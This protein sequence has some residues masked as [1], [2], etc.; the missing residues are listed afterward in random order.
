MVIMV[1]M[2]LVGYLVIKSNE[3]SSMI[4]DLHTLPL[5]LFRSMKQSDW[6]ISIG[7]MPLNL[8]GSGIYMKLFP[9]QQCHQLVP[10]LILIGLNVVRIAIQAIYPTTVAPIK[11]QSNVSTSG[12]SLRLVHHH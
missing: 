2:K 5:G 11:L 7:M 10:I 8:N 4:L 12:D 6:N 3:K 1:G 9:Q